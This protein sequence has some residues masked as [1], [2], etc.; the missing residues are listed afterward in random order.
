MK[1]LRFLA[2]FL[3]SQL[4]PAISVAHGLRAPIIND[5]NAVT[6]KGDIPTP[7]K[8]HSA[9]QA[10]QQQVVQQLKNTQQYLEAI[11]NASRNGQL[12][13]AQQNYIRAHQSYE[14]VRVIVKLFG[15][16][17]QNINS[18]ADY[19]LQGINDPGFSGFHRL[20]YELFVRK[21][22][23]QA[24]A[25]ASN[26]QYGI[27][28]LQKRVAADELDI[29][30][31]VQAA[32]DFL[33]MILQTKLAGKENQ[34]SHSDLADIHANVTG[35]AQI[36]QQLTDFIPAEQ[37]VALDSGYQQIFAVLRRYQLPQN[38]F[39][40]FNQ[41]SQADHDQ[42]YSLLSIQTNRLAQLRAQLGIRVYYKYPH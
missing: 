1:L 19:Y 41:L 2:L 39:Q 3:C 38:Q 35:S 37:R 15:N 28:D 25:E 22:L 16:A 34:Y 6:A 42:L 40:N 9:I 23:Q 5:T 7:E 11:V 21:D 14:Q 12:L 26:L 20:E 36:V 33:E 27:I 31:V 24:Q 10:Y 4:L 30:K 18:R 17:D 13:P 8:Y 29:A 32:S